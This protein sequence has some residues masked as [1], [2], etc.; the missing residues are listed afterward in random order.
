MQTLEITYI[1]AKVETNGSFVF[2]QKL[3][4]FLSD[5][6]LC[7]LF[8]TNINL[9]KIYGDL[10][11]ALSDIFDK[12]EE[13]IIGLTKN[14][15]NNFLSKEFLDNFCQNRIV[16]SSDDY[17]NT[18]FSITDSLTNLLNTPELKTFIQ[19]QEKSGLNNTLE[20]IYSSINK[21]NYLIG[22]C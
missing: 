3:N 4:D 18:Y 9:H 14:N 5:L 22:L 16:E 6:K 2:C 13:E 11:E 7:H 20:E 19:S 1:A 8:T 17:K 15:C 21:A 10:Y 12:F